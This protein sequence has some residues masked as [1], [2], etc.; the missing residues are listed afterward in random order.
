MGSWSDQLENRANWDASLGGLLHYGLAE[1]SERLNQRLLST[2]LSLIIKSIKPHTSPAVL[3]GFQASLSFCYMKAFLGI[4][5]DPART[6]SQ[7]P[8]SEAF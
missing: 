2:V 6:A 5:L 3:V 1:S 7:L 4:C 8:S